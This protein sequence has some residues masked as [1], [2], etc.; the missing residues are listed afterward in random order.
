[1]TIKAA[2]SNAIQIVYNYQVASD[3]QTKASFKRMIK[4]L[5]QAQRVLISEFFKHPNANYNAVA[6]DK[7]NT[8]LVLMLDPQS[9]YIYTRDTSFFADVIR[10]VKNLLTERITSDSLIDQITVDGKVLEMSP[11]K[12]TNS[13]WVEAD[14]EMIVK[15]NQQEAVQILSNLAEMMFVEGFYL[16]EGF[17][18]I[19]GSLTKIKELQL[20]IFLYCK[21][22]GFAPSALKLKAIVDKTSNDADV[23]SGVFKRILLEM[24]LYESLPG[25]RLTSA[26]LIHSNPLAAH[27]I[28]KLFKAISDNQE[29]TLLSKEHLAIACPDLLS[30]IL[31]E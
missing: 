24:S 9:N 26:E 22:H 6:L 5:T 11:H 25:A 7:V 17:M 19:P 2:Q 14:L 20:E 10:W 3:Q 15:P 28:K 21:S 12:P 30:F 29:I 1:M 8:V 4:E 31:Q 27:N 13:I 16:N 23:I 18:R